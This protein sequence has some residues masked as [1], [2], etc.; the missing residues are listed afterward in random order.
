MTTDGAVT[1]FQL[2]GQSDSHNGAEDIVTGPDGAMW[3]DLPKQGAIGRV[4]ASGT[5]DEF[6]LSGAQSQCDFV[7]DQ[8]LAAGS[9]G[10]MW[11]GS[12]WS[13]GIRRVTPD[14]T[15]ST[16]PADHTSGDLFSIT[17]GSDGSLYYTTAFSSPTVERLSTSGQITGSWGPLDPGYPAGAPLITASPNGKPW[18]GV[19]GAIEQLDPSVLPI[20]PTPTG[21]GGNNGTVGAAPTPT[22]APPGDATTTPVPGFLNFPSP[23]P[24]PGTGALASARAQ[25]SSGSFLGI[26]LGALAAVVLAGTAAGFLIQRRLKARIKTRPTP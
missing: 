25:T 2:P 19:Q 15:V 17:A 8:D 16:Y 26:L 3:F 11:I 12:N 21:S 6:P 5:V 20:G 14:G 23:S 18:I 24:S 22:A 4:T 7:A 10:A 9:D 13:G 1:T